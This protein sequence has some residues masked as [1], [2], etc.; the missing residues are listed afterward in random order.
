VL[1][2]LGYDWTEDPSV[3]TVATLSNPDIDITAVNSYLDA[4]ADQGMIA[5]LVDL[6][7]LPQSDLAGL[8]D[9]YPYVPDV[10]DLMSGALTNNDVAATDAATSLALLTGDLA[11][12]T[13]P[14]AVDL[15]S[16]FPVMATDLADYFQSLASFL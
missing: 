14:I 2:D 4:G 7:I 9:M 15:G 8:A 3:S 6:G 12:S 1:V 10:S 13:N 11:D 5:Y 16:Y